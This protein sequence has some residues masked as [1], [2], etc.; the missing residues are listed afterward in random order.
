MV[1]CDYSGYGSV[2]VGVGVAAWKGSSGGVG[3][4]T[5]PYLSHFT[6]T[7]SPT[8]MCTS[9]PPGLGGTYGGG[10]GGTGQ[11]SA[12]AYMG[13]SLA[14]LRLRAHEYSLHQGQV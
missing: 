11:M 4:A 3:S 1:M 13:S 5:P 10:V 12:G 2:G 9:L 6:P 7:S 14:S 8:P